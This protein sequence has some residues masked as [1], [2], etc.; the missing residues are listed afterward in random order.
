MQRAP[1]PPRQPAI[2]YPFWG[3]SFTGPHLPE[4]SGGVEGVYLHPIP[5][6][7]LNRLEFD[8]SF[9]LILLL[10]KYQFSIDITIKK[11]CIFLRTCLVPSSPYC[12]R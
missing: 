6:Q 3:S 11:N 4:G 8:I 10:Y 7:I 12:A 2:G 5:E 1:H 9:V